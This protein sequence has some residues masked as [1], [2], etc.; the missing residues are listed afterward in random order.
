[1]K[2]FGESS[3]QAS[4]QIYGALLLTGPPTKFKIVSSLPADIFFFYFSFTVD[5]QHYFISVSGVQH[6]GQTII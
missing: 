6:C 5:I 1:M 2:I 4:P 3:Q